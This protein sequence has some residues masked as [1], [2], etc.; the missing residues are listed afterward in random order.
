MDY[1]STNKL[2][3]EEATREIREIA[4]IGFTNPTFHCKKR[5]KQKNYDIQDV[6]QILSTGK[7][8]KPAE[9]DSD[10]DDWKYAVEGNAIERDKATVIVTIVSPNEILCITIMDK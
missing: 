9:W 6:D 8:R 4:R 5:M 3:P 7:V 10:Y 2:L 1:N